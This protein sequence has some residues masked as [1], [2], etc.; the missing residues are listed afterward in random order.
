[1]FFAGRA[2][3]LAE[4]GKTDRTNSYQPY[5]SVQGFARY[6]ELRGRASDV[7]TTYTDIE[8]ELHR[9]VVAR[10]GEPVVM[11][12]YS[13][14]KPA[15]VRTAKSGMVPVIVSISPTTVTA[16]TNDVL[17]ITGT[18]F[19]AS[20]GGTN[21]RV[22]FANADD[23]GNTIIAA[24]AGLV[25]S[26]SDTQIQVRVPSRAGTGSVTVQT[27]SSQ[28]AT[29]AATLT[30]E[31]NLLTLSFRRRRVENESCKQECRRLLAAHEYE[32]VGRR[33]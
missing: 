33:R 9:A 12:A 18:G 24:P 20:D 13:V 26:W 27:A 11:K 8:Q 2:T 19:E 30:I 3:V 4:A 21:S 17:T 31:Y 6:D 1:M 10:T 29:S 16:G 22:F 7:F 32:N 28:Q 15:E 14:P 25:S 23:G 5:A